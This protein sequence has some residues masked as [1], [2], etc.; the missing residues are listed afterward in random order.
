MKEVMR[1]KRTTIDNNTISSLAKV[2]TIKLIKPVTLL[3]RLTNHKKDETKLKRIPECRLSSSS[4]IPL[5]TTTQQN[6]IF[7]TSSSH[8]IILST[9]SLST[10][11][12]RKMTSYSA[13]KRKAQRQTDLQ[14]TSRFQVNL[15]HVLGF[16]SISNSL[17]SQDRT[18]LAYAAGSTVVLY[19]ITSQKQ[20]FIINNARKAITS[21][22]LSPDGKFLVTGEC[23]HEP[24]VRVW[25]VHD[26]SQCVELG[27]HKFAID[28][29]SFCPNVERLVSIGSLHDGSIY[30]W[31]WREKKKLASNKCTCAVRRIAFAED[32]SYFVTV[33]N[34]H[35]K[36]WYLSAPSVEVI[37]LKGRLAILAER[38]DNMFTDVVCG[39]GDCANMTYT[40]THNGLVSQF[41]EHRQMCAEKDLKEKAN[42]LAIG[43]VYLIV[44][45]SSGSV[46]IFSP[47][48]LDYITSLPRPHF[49]G[50]DIG[51]IQSLD[52]LICPQHT[53]YFP[54]TIA[55]CLDEDNAI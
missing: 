42:C 55:L 32:G 43:D 22:S 36:F 4:Q 54:D 14:T 3:R 9:P 12:Q 26:K 29:V 35:V 45:C 21:L 34:R 7:P 38:K 15:E 18:T 49:L 39:R 2:S 1:H 51:F 20:D 31:G 52:Q 41:N 44:G 6:S 25:D 17:V 53:Q 13:L 19:N 16:T 24:K 40:I 46:F 47:Q 27:D 11:R 50:V 37:P 33:G 10:V 23:G 28:C 5:L 48:N 30:V 8:S